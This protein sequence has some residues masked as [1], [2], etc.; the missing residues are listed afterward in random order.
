VLPCAEGLS[1]RQAAEAVRRRMNRK[2][3]VSLEVIDPG[4]DHTVPSEF[5]TRLVAG[6]TEQRLLDTLLAQG[7]ERGSSN[8][9]DANASTPPMSSLPFASST[10]R[11]VWARPCAMP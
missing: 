2:Y 1:D 11:S 8:P 10:A 5:R 6:Q 4:F 9:T 7:R 3:T